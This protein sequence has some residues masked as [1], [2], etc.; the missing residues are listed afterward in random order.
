MS[1]MQN[2]TQYQPS[3]AVA[4][5]GQLEPIE[6]AYMK[7]VVAN[8]H[9]SENLR[10]PSEPTTWKAPVV[11]RGQDTTGMRYTY[12]GPYASQKRMPLQP[13]GVEFA[14]PSVWSGEFQPDQRYQVDR[15]YYDRLFRAGYPGFNLGLSFKVPT[16]QENATGGPGYNLRMTR[17][18]QPRGKVNRIARTSGAPSVFKPNNIPPNREI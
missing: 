1:I 3:Q 11:W 18:P 8:G 17:L 9:I 2:R 16:L 6:P 10:I 5:A 13:L 7:P 12:L 15:G 4:V 14:G